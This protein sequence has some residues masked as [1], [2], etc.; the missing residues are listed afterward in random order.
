LTSLA[1]ALNTTGLL[2][3][4]SSLTDTTIFAPFNDAFRAIGSA[5]KTPDTLDLA[6]I[7]GY[8]VLPQ[9]VLFSTEFLSED[10]MTFGTLQGTNVTVRRDGKQVF[11]NSA[12]VVIADILTS[13]GVLHVLDK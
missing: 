6:G 7:L 1:G 9:Q 11:V 4:I 3:G 5:F 10:R 12:R 8:H 2:E 13:N